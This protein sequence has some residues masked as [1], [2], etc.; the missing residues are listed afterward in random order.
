MAH[1][2][3]VMVILLSQKSYVTV[4]YLWDVWLI[5]DSD[6]GVKE[7][8]DG[9]RPDHFGIH[10]VSKETNLGE[11]EIGR[12]RENE[13]RGEGREGRKT[14]VSNHTCHKRGTTKRQWST[15]RSVY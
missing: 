4:H 3:H 5:G 9:G 8:H 1:K 10:Q 15:R 11:G 6:E 13:K 12:T 2:N 7:T 14:S